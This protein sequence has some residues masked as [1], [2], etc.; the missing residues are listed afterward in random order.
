MVEAIRA[1]RR[2]ASR[3]SGG[4]LP[5]ETDRCPL[6]AVARVL[7]GLLATPVSPAEVRERAMAFGLLRAPGSDE[8][9]ELTAQTTSRLLLAGYRL[10]AQVEAAGWA[11]V[12]RHVR[13]GRL[14][15]LLLGGGM[16]PLPG[17]LR[18]H[19]YLAAPEG[20]CLLV[21]APEAPAAAADR[22]AAERLAE[23]WAAAG[24][25]L[26]VG[27]RHWDELPTQGSEFFAGLRDRDGSYHWNTAECD[28]D[29]Q[30]H[31]LRY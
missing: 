16:A 27:L 4:M 30:G 3:T 7:S 10:P 9:T 11:E 22:I 15:F 12:A 20:D 18:V 6:A 14:V 29:A 8:G 21:A 28:T 26:V 25:L 5:P 1:A 31:I 13:A 24:N 23:S 2:R 17:V 19:D